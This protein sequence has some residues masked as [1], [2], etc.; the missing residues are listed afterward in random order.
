MTNVRVDQAVAREV[1]AAYVDAANQRDAVTVAAFAQLVTETDHLFRW[2]TQ[3][4]RPGALQVFFTACENPY[5]DAPELIASV[6]EVRTL[7]VTT[8]AV[9]PHRRHPLMSNDLGGAYD[10]FRAIHD[11]LGHA[12][13]QLGFDRDGEYA[14]LA[15]AGAIPQSTRLSGAWHRIARTTQRALDDRRDR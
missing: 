13:L 1:A 7:E 5:R 8:V 6:T 10:R 12:R 11:T 14:G 15:G 9:D 3:L 4:S 2:I